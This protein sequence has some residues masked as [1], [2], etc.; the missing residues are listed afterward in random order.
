MHDETKTKRTLTDGKWERDRRQG[1]WTGD[2]GQG[3]MDIMEIMDSERAGDDNL[4]MRKAHAKEKHAQ[5]QQQSRC[6]R[7]KVSFPD[8]RSVSRGG[9]VPSG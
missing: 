5:V 2:R 3:I 1:Q 8:R 9:G 7:G 6:S 4:I